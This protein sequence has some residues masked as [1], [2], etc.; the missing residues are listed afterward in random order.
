MPFQIQSLIDS[1]KAAPSKGGLPP[2]IE[3]QKTGDYLSIIANTSQYIEKIRTPQVSHLLFEVQGVPFKAQHLP[4]DGR[5][6]DRLV[7]WAT[8]GY[9]PF[10]MV[11]PV[12]RRCLIQIL[13]QTSHLKTVKFGIDQEMRIVAVGSFDVAKPLSPLYLF[14]PLVRFM[15]EARPFINLIGEYL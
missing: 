8:L 2:V 13:E 6:H 7:I 10:S 11:S 3:A 9:M 4:V 5:P 12:Q 14:E 1:T 15:Q